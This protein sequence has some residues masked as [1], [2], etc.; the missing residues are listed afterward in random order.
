MIAATALRPPPP[1]P[2]ERDKSI[3]NLLI[4]FTSLSSNLIAGSFVSVELWWGGGRCRW[5]WG[6]D[7]WG[8]GGGMSQSWRRK[9]VFVFLLFISSM[10]GGVFFLP[11][12]F[13]ETQPL[14]FDSVCSVFTAA[15]LPPSVHNSAKGKHTR[16]HT[17]THIGGEKDRGEQSFHKLSARKN[18]ISNINARRSTL[19]AI[20]LLSFQKLVF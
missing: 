14:C 12:A 16:T 10:R 4:Y 11:E 9:E 7:K 17:R 2:R 5:C 18:L 19:C 15:T 1:H 3:N 20:V 6:G 8:E 13:F